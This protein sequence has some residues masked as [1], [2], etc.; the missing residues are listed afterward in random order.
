MATMWGL[1]EI[2]FA[3]A[4]RADELV[5]DLAGRREL[6]LDPDAALA[7]FTLFARAQPGREERALELEAA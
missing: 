7:G 2:C 5:A 3:D 4:R 1:I 6:R